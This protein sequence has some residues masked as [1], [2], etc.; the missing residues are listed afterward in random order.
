M[1]KRLAGNQRPRN[2]PEKEECI[3]RPRD[4]EVEPEAILYEPGTLER[5]AKICLSEKQ[6]MAR[7]LF[8]YGLTCEAVARILHIDT[9]FIRDTGSYPENTKRSGEK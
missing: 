8:R 7:E 3:R 9:E 4:T 2:Q 6:A 5:F 1:S